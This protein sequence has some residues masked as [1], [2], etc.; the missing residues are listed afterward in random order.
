MMRNIHM[1][2]AYDGSEFSGWQRIP[3][4]HTI[5]GY[6]E[7]SFSRLLRE[8]IV[9]NGSG[10]TDKGVHALGQSLSFIYTGSIPTEGLKP[11]LGNKLDESIRILEVGQRP[12]DFHAR[13]SARAKTYLYKINFNGDDA[14]FFR[15]YF[16][17]TGPLDAG[18]MEKASRALVG[19]HD[20]TAFS[21]RRDRFKTVNPHREIKRI[22][23]L[24]HGDTLW[25]R[26]T[27]NGF[28]YHMIRLMVYHLVEVGRGHRQASST[29]E[30][31]SSASRQGTSRLAPA[32]GLYLESVDY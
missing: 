19:A 25:I 5:Q 23:F 30:I 29:Q 8:E 2:I 15:K 14:L 28:L 17:F 27:G 20:F 10:R 7:K 1:T 4:K 18:E 12:L 24:P 22:E 32:S 13:Y 16:W 6:L 31:L 26:F 11:Y 21:S 3:G 9:V